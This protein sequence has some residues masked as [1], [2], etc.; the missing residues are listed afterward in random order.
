[1]QSNRPS[2]SRGF[3]QLHD[4][5]ALLISF[6]SYSNPV[7]IGFTSQEDCRDLNFEAQLELGMEDAEGNLTTNLTNLR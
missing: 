3:P 7:W 5:A 1:M 2:E 6:D 4:F